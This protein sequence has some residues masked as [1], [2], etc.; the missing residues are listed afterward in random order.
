MLVGRVRWTSS[1]FHIRTSDQWIAKVLLPV[2][3]AVLSAICW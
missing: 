3:I 2:T 1:K